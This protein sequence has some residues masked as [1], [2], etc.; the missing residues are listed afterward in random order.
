[1]T[2]QG[3]LSAFPGRL[4]RERS[5]RGLAQQA[6]AQQLGTDAKTVSR[7]ENGQVIPSTY[8]RQ[9]LCA[10]FQMSLEDFGLIDMDTEKSSTIII[11]PAI[12]LLPAIPLIG[13]D[14]LV[15]ELRQR[16]CKEGNIALSALNGLPGVG[17]TAL[18]VALAHDKDIREHFADGILWAGLGPHPDVQSH[19]SRWGNLLGMQEGEMNQ[20]HDLRAWELAL[21][22][23]VGS[24]SFL[25]VVDDVWKV[26]D[27][28]ALKVGG[29]RCS[30]L[31]TTRFPS[32]ATVVAAEGAIF[33]HE[34]SLEAGLHLLEALAP[35]A[36]GQEQERV[37]NVA[38]AVGGLP[39]ALTLVGNYLRIQTYLNLPR[40]LLAAFQRLED[41]EAR[42]R[43]QETRGPGERHSSQPEE[44]AISL[45]SI[46]GLTDEQ[47]TS[48][49]REAFY[50]LSVFPAK[51]KSF[52]EE[53]AL[54]V[55]DCPIEILDELIDTG[56][57]Q[58]SQPNR[59]MLHQTIADYARVCLQRQEQQ[60][61][62]ATQRFIQYVQHFV[63]ANKSAYDM[64]EVESAVIIAALEQAKDEEI[65]EIV[66]N[67]ALFLLSRGL[68]TF[69]KT[70]LH[71]AFAVA[72]PREQVEL[73]HLQGEITLRTGNFAEA[74][75]L[76]QQGLALARREQLPETV[77]F[78]SNLGTISW[79]QGNYPLAKQYLEEGLKLNAQDYRLLGTL[80]SVYNRLGDYG[81]AE[82][83]LRQALFYSQ[84]SLAYDPTQHC[85]FLS[86]LAFGVAGQGRMEEGKQVYHEA[87]ALAYQA[88]HTE[89]IVMCLN[90]IADLL[91]AEGDVDAAEK[92]FAE[93]LGLARKMHLR[94]WIC[95]ILVGLATIART[96]GQLE[97]AQSALQESLE[98]ARKLPIPQMRAIGLFEQSQIALK[99]GHANLA[100]EFLEEIESLAL[101]DDSEVQ[102]LLAFGQAHVCATHQNFAEAKRLG[103]HALELAVY[104]RR[105]I[106]AWLQTLP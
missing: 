54:V 44:S 51:P 19:L 40:R 36:V 48:E 46:I 99:Q 38:L 47:L 72:S 24:R 57:M 9:K 93:G 1:M 98:L 67:F 61:Q 89:W 20:L 43:L 2:Q 87:L 102:G 59:Y 23:A 103:A 35:E 37:R 104:Y 75:P 14:S 28:L 58:S 74:E 10:F 5:H 32:I 94:E 71:R 53:A 62:K 17:K 49:G 26:E 39:L 97:K 13:R 31:I 30:H 101:Q 45:A 18:A 105:D 16:L 25:F 79:K 3:K 66:S 42:L 76:F 6:L 56:L 70:H 90:N 22:Q 82:Q 68:Y 69:A 27:A 50:A 88:G 33:L 77:L 78:L 7:W 65:P 34:L 60:K 96:K 63:K 84:H 92:T 29:Q 21:H 8:F 91:R 52:S 11:D 106:Q 73:L 83:L 64:L 15:V 41:A 12:P 86:A 85:V 80:G 55:A 95:V 100:E 4:K 81:H